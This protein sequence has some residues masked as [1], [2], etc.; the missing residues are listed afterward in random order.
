MLMKLTS[1]CYF[2]KSAKYVNRSVCFFVFFFVS[3]LA[4]LRKNYWTDSL[5]IFTVCVYHPWHGSFR[6]LCLFVCLFVC[7]WG[8]KGRFWPHTFQWAEAPESWASPFF[9]SAVTLLIFA[10]DSF[11]LYSGVHAVSKIYCSLIFQQIRPKLGLG[12]SCT[13]TVLLFVVN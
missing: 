12:I 9:S 5:Q 2:A 10:V 7:Y 8:K 13:V 3:M 1:V 4:R 6:K 11:R